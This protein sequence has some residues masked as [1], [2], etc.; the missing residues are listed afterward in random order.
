MNAPDA[1]VLHRRMVEALVAA[2]T[3]TDDWRPAFDA[4]PRHAFV[5]NIT[6][7]HGAANGK[8]G[9]I[10]RHRVEDPDGWLS[11]A[12][13]DDSV[14][15]Q[16]DDGDPAG[17]DGTGVL[18]TS[19]ISM[20][21]VVAAMLRALDVHD[22]QKVLEIGT[23]T[24]YNAALLAHRLG[25]QH[26]TTVE[27]DP[28][29]ARAAR[30]GL[31]QTG[32]RG[33]TV[34]TADGAQGMAVHAPYDRVL[35]TASCQQVPYPWVAQ[36][37]PGGMV[38]TPWRNAYHPGGLLSLIVGADGTAAGRIVDCAWFMQL[39]DQRVPRCTVA[40]VVCGDY[41]GEESTTSIGP[42][43]LAGHRGAMLAISLQVPHCRHQYFPYDPQ[44]GTG[45]LWFLDPW[46][47]SWASHVHT[48]PDCSDDEFSVR[49]RG[50]RRLW[51]EIF[52]AHT[53][54][55]EQGRPDEQHW[56][57]TVH[58][59]GQSID[60]TPRNAIAAG[61]VSSDRGAVDRLGRGK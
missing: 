27:I 22:G 41:Q 10:P 39:R 29:V 54:W 55:T 40:D 23:G 30:H 59:A 4:V 46:S 45:E 7:R 44:D 26:V 17:P 14:I 56:T 42:Y 20:P 32:Y 50:P 9:F 43:E 24:G 13:Q 12:Y 31:D 58:P 48:T 3:L 11:A 33:I 34:V 53:W 49:Q 57:F 25:A 60:L 61:L 6:W 52:A 5:P 35:S 18:P 15:T 2:G 37:V 38:L 8:W 47:G 28:A 16:V 21:T 36:T 51:D 1:E 19:S